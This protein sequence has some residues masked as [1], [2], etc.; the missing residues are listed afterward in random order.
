MRHSTAFI[1]KT[2][3]NKKLTGAEIGVSMGV[4]SISINENLNMKK[5]YLID[6]WD[7]F[8][9][10]GKTYDST[11]SYNHVKKI[12]KDC[13]NVD[14]IKDDSVK[15]AKTIKDN[16]LDFVYIDGNHQYE[17][18][19]ADIEAWYPKVK[20]GGIISGHDYRKCWKG[21]IKAVDEFVKKYN[22]KLFIKK[23]KIGNEDW[24]FQK[25]DK[26]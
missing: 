22:Y 21:V 24:W 20:I 7:K 2:F 9:L 11:N 6:I 26:K 12:F 4:N 16:T 8:L 10:D 14:I 18:V 25:E 13:K 3:G 17:Y 1:K 5:L 15:V 23:N 19:K